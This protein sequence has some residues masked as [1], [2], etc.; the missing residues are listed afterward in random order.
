MRKNINF[1]WSHANFLHKIGR[2]RKQSRKIC[3]QNSIFFSLCINL[4]KLIVLVLLLL[5]EELLIVQDF[6]WQRPVV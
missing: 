1:D 2:H 6:D 5:S 4:N 3:W